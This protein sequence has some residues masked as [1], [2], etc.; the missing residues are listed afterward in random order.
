M[1]DGRFRPKDAASWTSKG[2]QSTTQDMR[3]H[4]IARAAEGAMRRA[5]NNRTDGG[6]FEADEPIMHALVTGEDPTIRVVSEPMI[7][8]VDTNSAAMNNGVV[9]HPMQPGVAAPINGT[10]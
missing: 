5:W 3:A 7:P 9:E 8:Q 4:V 2:P 6:V 1:E 10:V